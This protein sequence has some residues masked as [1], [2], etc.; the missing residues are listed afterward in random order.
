MSPDQLKTIKR[1]ADD[2][3]LQNLAPFDGTYPDSWPALISIK[4]GSYIDYSGSI[5]VDEQDNLPVIVVQGMM[6]GSYKDCCDFFEKQFQKQV[7]QS[8]ED[9]GKFTIATKINP[10]PQGKLQFTVDPGNMLVSPDSSSYLFEVYVLQEGE[11][12]SFGKLRKDFPGW[13]RFRVFLNSPHYIR[14]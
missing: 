3:G 6:P 11:G 13:C 1:H 8:N 12:I 2:S 5:V 14:D 4:Q 9:K 7:H 10:D